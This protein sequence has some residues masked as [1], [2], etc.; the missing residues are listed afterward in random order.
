MSTSRSWAD[1]DVLIGNPSGLRSPR[2]DDHDLPTSTLDR[3]EVAA[4]SRAPLEEC[5]PLGYEGIGP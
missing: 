4:D 1:R 3:F 5:H 2:V